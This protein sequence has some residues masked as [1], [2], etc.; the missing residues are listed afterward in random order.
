MD[1]LKRAFTFADINIRKEYWNSY[2][3]MNDVII[4]A[5]NKSHI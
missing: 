1:T 4:N 2:E 5:I 3:E